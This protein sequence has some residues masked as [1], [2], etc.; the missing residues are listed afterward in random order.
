MTWINFPYYALGIILCWI[1]GILMLIFSY[2][3]E[4]FEK[5][6]LGAFII[7]TLIQAIFILNLWQT[8]ERPPLRTLGETRLWYSFFYTFN[9]IFCLCKMAL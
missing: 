9:R 7:G 8:L 3:K 1:I 5:I 2:K 4:S 6:A